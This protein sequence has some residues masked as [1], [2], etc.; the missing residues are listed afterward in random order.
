MFGGAHI[1]HVPFEARDDPSSVEHESCVLGVNA[2]RIRRCKC[3]RASSSR[4]KAV[5]WW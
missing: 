2:L 4:G 5:A 3:A 1:A